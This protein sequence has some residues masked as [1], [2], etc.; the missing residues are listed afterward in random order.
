MQRLTQPKRILGHRLAGIPRASI[1]CPACWFVS[2][3]L[4]S[5]Q[6]SE[7]TRTWM[8]TACCKCGRAHNPMS[9]QPTHTTAAL[10]SF[11]KSSGHLMTAEVFEKHTNV[12]L[13]LSSHH[14]APKRGFFYDASSNH[15]K[16]QKCDFFIASNTQNRRRRSGEPTCARPPSGEN[17]FS[18]AI[19]I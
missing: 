1:V 16:L 9:A 2:V 11:H 17:F 10:P 3:N 6:E 19:D 8:Q 15:T 7:R 4:S 14:Y 5:R 13:F 18:P 12:L